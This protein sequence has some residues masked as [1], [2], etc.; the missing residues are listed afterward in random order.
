MLA[1][2]RAKHNIQGVDYEDEQARNGKKPTKKKQKKNAYVDVFNL[3]VGSS[4]ESD[5]EDEE[6]LG[7]ADS[8]DG[9]NSI[10][11]ADV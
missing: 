10:S 7:P 5:D 4:D 2:L 9:G 3:E 6:K 8:D 1:K 11:K